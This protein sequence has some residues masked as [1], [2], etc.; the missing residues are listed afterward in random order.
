MVSSLNPESL[1][2]FFFFKK[3]GVSA[4]TLEMFLPVN[5]GKCDSWPIN[6]KA[7]F[8]KSRLGSDELLI[9]VNDHVL[10]FFFFLQ[11]KMKGGG[12]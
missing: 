5:V 3:K 12:P 7:D 10:F 11:K 6:Y 8:P 9:L 1:F 4:V 2:F